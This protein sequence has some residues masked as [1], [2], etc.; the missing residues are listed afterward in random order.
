[1]ELALLGEEVRVRD[2][3]LASPKASNRL[4]APNRENLGK[5]N[6]KQEK[7]KKNTYFLYFSYIFLIFFLYFSSRN[8]QTSETTRRQSRRVVS[9]K[10]RRGDRKVW[11][12]QEEFR[13]MTISPSS[14]KEKCPHR[15][16]CNICNYTLVSA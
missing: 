8:P 10:K 1:M 14:I 15:T 16:L 13:F 9:K 3:D 6:K 11:F 5:T 4:G 7:P 2:R 12:R